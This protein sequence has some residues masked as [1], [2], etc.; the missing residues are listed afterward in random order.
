MHLSNACANG[1][2]EV[3]MTLIEKGADV[4]AKDHVN[5]LISILTIWHLF[6]VVVIIVLF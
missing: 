5:C 2:L 6:F 3:A 4:N 1:L